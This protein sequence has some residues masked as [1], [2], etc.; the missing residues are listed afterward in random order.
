VLGVGACCSGGLTARLALAAARAPL[1]YVVERYTYSKGETQFGVGN[2]GQ[3]LT[4]NAN[5]QALQIF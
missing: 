5:V 2:N 1:P 3:G 4:H